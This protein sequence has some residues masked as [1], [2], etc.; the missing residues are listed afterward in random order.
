MWWLRLEKGIEGNVNSCTQCQMLQPEPPV[1]SFQPWEL[2]TRPWAR[3]HLDF[4]GPLFEKTLLILI[5]AHLKW[6]E[7]YQKIQPHQRLW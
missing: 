6:I 3:L 5:D 1:A 2:P 4:A 7:L